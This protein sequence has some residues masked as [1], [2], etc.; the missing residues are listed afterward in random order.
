M[1]QALVGVC[2]HA[3]QRRILDVTY[4]SWQQYGKRHGLP[5][6][7]IEGSHA[8]GDFYWNKHLLFRVPELRSAKRL[9]FLDNDVFATS[10]AGP[11]LQEWDSPLIGATAESTQ[12]AWLPDFIDRYYEEYSV[13]RP[14]SLSDL[15]ILNTGVL[16]IPREQ[17]E[18]LE[19]VYQE[20]RARK[21]AAT[22]SA[23]QSRDPF[24]R[25]A[26][27]P[28][29]SYALQAEHRYQDFGVRY[30]T[31]WWHW[32][33]QQVSPRQMP[34]LLRSKAAALTI[35]RMPQALWQALFRR[36]RATFARAL[37]D[38]GFLHVAGSKSS[39][40]LGK[41]WKIARLLGPLTMQAEK[42]KIAGLRALW[43]FDNRWQLI[44]SRTFFP[45]E[46]L[47]TYK[48][49]DLEFLVDHAAG[50]H[51]GTRLCL[52][53]DIYTRFLLAMD[54]GE[55]I[56]VFDL[57]AKGGGFPLMLH[58]H[59]KKF[60]PRLRRNESEHLRPTAIQHRPEY[61]WRGQP[62][63]YGSLRSQPDVGAAFRA[64]L[65]FRYDLPGGH[66]SRVRTVPGCREDL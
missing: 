12:A 41:G 44:I 59:G 25:A 66:G 42:N 23:G 56:S 19:R 15:Q 20:W 18:F 34:F 39:L 27:Q 35:D 52:I 8:G 7:I 58:L 63:A 16:V 13:P 51:N 24:V 29:V 62:S 4:P 1:D 53:S 17:A 5:V 55:T 64:R 11:L 9:L 30:N 21:N 33:R 46:S 54:L 3:R 50:D 32:Y 48:K 10:S 36:E 22:K 47:L 31:L 60:A 61:P 14:Q 26:D 37:N 38:S 49:D 6:I 57:G 2:Y 28:H 40:F 45:R 43:Q 65:H